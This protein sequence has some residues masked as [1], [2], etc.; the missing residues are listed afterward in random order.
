MA[1]DYANLK[2]IADTLISENGR[3]M[4]LVKKDLTHPANVA[5]PWRANLTT[6]QITITVTGVF[7]EFT[8]ED[9]PPSLDRKSTRTVLVSA[10]S[11]EALA[12]ADVNIEDYHTLLDGGV[13]FRIVKA[14]PLEPGDTRILYILEVEK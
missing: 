10:T 8:E 14:E 9:Q 7:A 4:S 5:K 6:D 1:L 11:V 2:A 3:S 12:P 13:E